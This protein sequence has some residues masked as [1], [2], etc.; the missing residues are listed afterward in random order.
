MRQRILTIICKI[1]IAFLLL[2]AA[3]DSCHA[4]A[5]NST[6]VTVSKEKVRVGGKICYSHIVL[7]KQTLY[8][9]SKAYG[10]SVEDIY[11]Y[12]PAV[13]E[14]GL[15][16]N[17]IIIIPSREALTENTPK[18]EEKKVETRKP[19]AK[20]PEKPQTPEIAQEPLNEATP[21]ETAKGQKVHIRKWYED[22]DMIAELYGVSVESIMTANKLTGRKLSK[23]QR[24]IIPAKETLAEK[25]TPQ[26][27]GAD[28]QSRPQQAA[29][30]KPS[31]AEV[32]SPQQEP[33]VE[34]PADD[35]YLF[36]KDEVHA[37][38]LLPMR[39]A[40]GRLSRN[41][42]DFYSGLMLAV[43]D[44]AQEGINTDINVYDLSDQS[45]PVTKEDIEESDMIIGPISTADLTRLFQAS[46]GGTSPVISPLDPR[47]ER[48]IATHRNM[49]QVPTPHKAQYQDLVNW[50]KEDME[51]HDKVFMFS[52]RIARS[53]DAVLAMKEV[54][55][56]SGIEYTSFAYSILEGRDIIEPLKGMMSPDGVNRI[57]IASESEAFVNDVV[58]NLNLMLVENFQVVLYAPSKIR[59]FDTIEVEHFHKTSMHVSLTYFINYE[60]QEVKNFLLKYRALYKTEPTQ[61]AF[62]GYDIG[63]YFISLCHKY[64]K[65]W[66]EKLDESEKPMLQ[67]TFRCI[68]QGHGG[69]VNNGVRRIV[70]ENGWTIRQV[71]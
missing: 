54:M 29:E 14:N 1:A 22:L 40:E 53:N 11:Q 61:F 70:Y 56:S 23:R 71:Q 25:Q 3:Q 2:A 33:L 48:L 24:L 34:T 9:I 36:P 28:E 30:Q 12:N 60:E 63:K 7:E 35:I 5:Y 66:P 45:T 32:E 64:G 8:S 47:A 38:V 20:I 16:K 13:R 67:S 58:R 39:N 26:Q 37:T 4:Q 68:K 50:I 17:S 59:S 41:N 31:L 49:I 69:Y 51:E 43:Y 18:V 19:E 27:E 42:M 10:V 44:L 6:P 15:K 46:P 57:Y 62:Q 52:E 65:R 55:D 21:T